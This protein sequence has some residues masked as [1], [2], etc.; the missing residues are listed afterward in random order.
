MSETPRQLPLSG[1]LLDRVYI[2]E[3]KLEPQKPVDENEPEP[4]V[5][6]GWDWRYSSDRSAFEVRLTLVIEPAKGRAY[7]ASIDTIG[8]FQAVVDQPSVPVDQFV[9][10]QAVAILLP[11]A[12]QHLTNLTVNTRPGA[13]YLPSLNITELMKD[14]DPE[15]TTGAG[16]TRAR[17]KTLV[18]QAAAPVRK[19]KPK[20]T[21]NSL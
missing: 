3:A 5:N 2:S 12:R 16:Q 10:L 20:V 13:Y 15:K 7:R 9:R 19:R 6:F 14:F 21:R 1:Y 11:Y 8:R 18:D 4:V 17:A